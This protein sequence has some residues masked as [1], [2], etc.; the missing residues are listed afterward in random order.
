MGKPSTGN[1]RIEAKLILS[2]S[3][4][5]AEDIDGDAQIDSAGKK[6]LALAVTT[7]TKGIGNASVA[8]RIQFTDPDGTYVNMTA[9]ST[10]NI[11]FMSVDHTVSNTG[12]FLLSAASYG[13]PLAL[14]LP[15][16][17][18]LRLTPNAGAV[19]LI[20]VYAI[21]LAEWCNNG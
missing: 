21:L 15:S 20:E 18:R 10:G 1:N 4:A 6:L 5:A 2:G 9:V 3:S 14:V 19:T 12:Y 11:G 17:W 8:G 13:Y 16:A 7:Y